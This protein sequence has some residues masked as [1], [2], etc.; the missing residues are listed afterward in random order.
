MKWQHLELCSPYALL[1]T[2]G[3]FT[4]LQISATAITLWQMQNPYP[5]D[6]FFFFFFERE[7]EGGFTY[8]SQA[9]GAKQLVVVMIQAIASVPYLSMA[10]LIAE[11]LVWS[12]SPTITPSMMI[13]ENPKEFQKEKRRSF[14]ND[15]D[16]LLILLILLLIHHTCRH[17]GFQ[18]SLLVDPW[19]YHILWS[20]SLLSNGEKYQRERHPR[21]QRD[22]YCR[23]CTFH[24]WNMDRVEDQLIAQLGE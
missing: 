23:L 22:H 18:T 10:S 8:S 7:R 13:G 15:I 19:P 11:M 14:I 9:R 24:S 21:R 4:L 2:W 5:S 16:P 1:T 3:M 20:G 17:N 12:S 6:F